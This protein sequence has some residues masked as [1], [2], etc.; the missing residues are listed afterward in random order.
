MELFHVNQTE[1]LCVRC[2]IPFHRFLPPTLCQRGKLEVNKAS[3]AMQIKV[4]YNGNYLKE[5]QKQ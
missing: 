4:E 1:Q 3:Q 2:R 5:M